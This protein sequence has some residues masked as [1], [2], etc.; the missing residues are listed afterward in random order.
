M[1][2]LRI[3]IA[4]C[5]RIAGTHLEAL[6]KIDEV[7]VCGVADIR[8]EAAEQ[9]AANANCPAYTDYRELIDHE[10]PDILVVC[11]PPVTHPEMSIYALKHGSHVMCEKPF[12]VDATSAQKMMETA[13][14]NGRLISMA[15]KF[16]FVEDVTRS[17]ELIQGGIIG[18][19][20][21]LEIHFCG[22][23]DMR[24]RWYSDPAQS[25][26][27]VLLDNGSHAVDIFR[28]LLGPVSRVQAQHGRRVQGLRVEDTSMIFVETVDGVWGRIDLSWSMEK[29]HDTYLSIHGSDGM[30]TVGWKSAQYR[31]YGSKE[32]I[33]FGQGYDKLKAFVNQHK[34]FIDVVRGRATPV[35]N[36]TDSYESV[37][38]IEIAYWSARSNKWLEV[39]ECLTPWSTQRL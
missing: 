38:V 37:R 2:K 21:L 27:G 1:D 20:I 26:G 31:K 7:Q 32:W 15:S 22:V 3:G 9:F 13:E 25:G 8:R 24:G 28:Y 10:R 18:K 36:A 17:K 34:N 29:D 12:A 4:G 39:E 6:Q 33:Q 30:I 14:Q 16:R 5:G 11:T 19:M 23:A 35:I